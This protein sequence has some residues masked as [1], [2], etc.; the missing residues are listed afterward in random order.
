LVKIY[1]FSRLFAQQGRQYTYNRGEIW[2][3]RVNR[4]FILTRQV[5]PY[6]VKGKGTGAQ[7]SKFGQNCSISAV[8]LPHAGDVLYQLWWNLASKSMSQV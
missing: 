3:R 1:V 7:I 5:W 6:L 2:L 4:E 8:F